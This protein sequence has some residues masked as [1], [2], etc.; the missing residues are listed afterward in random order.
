MIRVENPMRERLTSLLRTLLMAAFTCWTAVWLLLGVAFV[1]KLV[2]GG[3]PEVR[4]YFLHDV[5]G[6][7]GTLPTS[8]PT[9]T[10]A[11]VAYGGN[12]LIWILL[13]LANRK[14][15]VSTLGRWRQS[16]AEGSHGAVR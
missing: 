9:W 1:R 4:Q 13:F 2:C 14:R 5:L 16:E 15:I 11:V 12:V 3:L 10:D 8:A 6:H 7:L